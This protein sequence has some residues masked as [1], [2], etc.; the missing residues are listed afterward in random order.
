MTSRQHKKEMLDYLVN[1]LSLSAFGGRVEPHSDRA[2]GANADY[3]LVG[4]SGIVLL[5]D[6]SF[7]S[8][9]SE[10]YRNAESKKANIAAV[11][12]KD[13]DTFFRSAA[14]ENYHKANT[15]GVLKKYNPAVNK[16]I[17]DGKNVMHRLMNLSSEEIFLCMSNCS[18]VQYYQPK[19]ARLNDAIVSYTF[20]PVFYDYSHLS[21]FEIDN[22]VEKGKIASKE[23]PVERAGNLSVW[24]EKEEIRNDGLVLFGQSLVGISIEELAEIAS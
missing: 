10:I 20:R 7:D 13:G 18:K 3:I 14:R 12:L 17:V 9:F 1:K 16:K 19:S 22:L 24:T 6:H 23:H 15:H 4:N 8:S 2:F 21:E 5:V 11:V